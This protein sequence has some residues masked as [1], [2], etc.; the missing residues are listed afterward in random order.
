[1]LLIIPGIVK[2]Y[3][4]FYVPYIVAENPDLPH[5]QVLALSSTLTKGDKTHIFILA[6]SFLGWRLLG[7]LAC[8]VGMLFV[9][10]Y[11]EVTYVELY[12]SASR[13]HSRLP[14]D[15]R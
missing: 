8:G 7:L 11:V 15:Q 1:M 10:P 2:S 12:I 14:V 6:L 5:S 13:D 9:T 4:Y 3:Q